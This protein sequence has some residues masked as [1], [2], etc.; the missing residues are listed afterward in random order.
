MNFI[1][2]RE[3]LKEFEDFPEDNVSLN[4]FYKRNSLCFPIPLGGRY[5]QVS[6]S[7]WRVYILGEK[8]CYFVG[9]DTK[10]KSFTNSL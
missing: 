9:S 1:V 4:S 8:K 10:S 6:I 5:F 7:G 3:L 2:F